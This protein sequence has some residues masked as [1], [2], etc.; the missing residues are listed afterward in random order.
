MKF[1]VRED[2]KPSALL[3]A[4]MLGVCITLFF[5]LGLDIVLHA[6]VLGA[7]L[8]AI[9]NTLYG[10]AETFIEPIL[11]DSL[12]LQVHIDLFMSLVSIMLIAS[13]YIRLYSTHFLT[14]LIVHLL[15]VLGLLSPVLLMIAYFTSIGFVHLWLLSFFLW[16]FLGMGMSFSIVWKLL[17]K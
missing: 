12:L 13:I 3:H 17:F 11:I 7:D 14:K 1:L 6:Y 15:F 9:S 8:I 16:H 5:Y 2:L 10:N 4:L